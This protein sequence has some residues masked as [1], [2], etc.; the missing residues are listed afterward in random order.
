MVPE[1]SALVLFTIGHMHSSIL[2]GI[3]FHFAAFYLAS[4]RVLTVVKFWIS[5][6]FAL[7]ITD[8]CCRNAH[9]V[10]LNWYRMNFAREYHVV[11]KF[12]VILNVKLVN[13]LQKQAR[14]S[15]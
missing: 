8:I 7:S 11:T 2:G 12:S 9:L 3:C 10:Y 6:C 1:L 14:L 15:L 4:F 13:L 5:K